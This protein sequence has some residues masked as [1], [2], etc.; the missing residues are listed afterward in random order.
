M[1]IMEILRMATPAL[2]AGGFTANRDSTPPIVK[3]M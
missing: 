1:S 2:F 3:E